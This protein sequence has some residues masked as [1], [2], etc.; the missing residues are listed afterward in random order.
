MNGRN[1]TNTNDEII[2]LLLADGLEN[3]LPKIAELLMNTAMLLERI[4][5]IGAAPYERNAGQRNGY[6]NGFKPRSFQT[7]VGKIKLDVPQVRNSDT[8]FQASLL[9]KGSRSDRSLKAAI[10]T[11]YVDLR[12]QDEGVAGGVGRIEMQLR[13]VGTAAPVKH[14]FTGDKVLRTLENNILALERLTV[15]QHQCTYPG[16]VFT[17]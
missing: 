11:M 6:A 4:Q 5:H 3:S 10:A 12:A 7:A 9:E 16:A 1:H 13:T 15:T 8:V 14:H 17:A 2:N